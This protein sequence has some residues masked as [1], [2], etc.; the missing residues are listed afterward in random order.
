MNGHFVKLRRDPLRHEAISDTGN[1]SFTEN[2]S[3]VNNEEMT[4]QR[5][6]ELAR[7]GLNLDVVPNHFRKYNNDDDDDDD[8]IRCQSVNN[9]LNRTHHNA[10]LNLPFLLSDIDP[11]DEC[12]SEVHVALRA[13][14]CKGATASSIYLTNE[15]H[16][17]NQVLQDGRSYHPFRISS[18]DDSFRCIISPYFVGMRDKSRYQSS[19]SSGTYRG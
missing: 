8:R 16:K 6:S 10:S 17:L 4:F 5:T 11:R 2:C 19:D 12:V 1:L 3:S 18:W 13:I 7:Y 9:V 14:K 15:F